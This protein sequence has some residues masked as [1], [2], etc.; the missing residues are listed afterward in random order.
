[1]KNN[2]NKQ[3]TL[4]TKDRQILEEIGY[5]AIFKTKKGV[6]IKN[7][8]ELIGNINSQWQGQQTP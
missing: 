8:K 2:D 7:K 6:I 1:M 5:K 3:I 4:T